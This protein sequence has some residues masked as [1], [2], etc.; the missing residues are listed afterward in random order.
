[1]HVDLLVKESVTNLDDHAKELVNDVSLVCS[2]NLQALRCLLE[3]RKIRVYDKVTSRRIQEEIGKLSDQEVGNEPWEG[4]S[5]DNGENGSKSR[6]KVKFNVH[7]SEVF[8]PSS[9]W[10]SSHPFGKTCRN[11]NTSLASRG[12][13]EISKDGVVIGQSA[14]HS[15]VANIG[16]HGNHGVV[17]LEAEVGMASMPEGRSHGKNEES[18][19]KFLSVLFIE[20][21][22]RIIAHPCGSMV[23]SHIGCIVARFM[24]NHTKVSE[25][26]RSSSLVALNI[27]SV[28]PDASIVALTPVVSVVHPVITGAVAEPVNVLLVPHV[29]L[30]DGSEVVV[31]HVHALCQVIVEVL[32]VIDSLGVL[33]VGG[34]VI[35]CL[36]GDG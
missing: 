10:L 20:S 29:L 23:V 28:I 4:N 27:T 11:L 25:D 9:C 5:E 24:D 8:T 13:L 17:K 6:E 2:G 36:F 33:I 16:D 31:P 26:T 21:P 15:L 7:I 12:S 35:Q 32:R 22:R 1:M 19:F 34:H 18:S 3:G 14:D 30:S